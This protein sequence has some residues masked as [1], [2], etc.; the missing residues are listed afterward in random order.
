MLYGVYAELN[1][2]RN[3]RKTYANNLRR[4]YAEI[5]QINLRKTHKYLTFTQFDYAEITQKLRRNYANKFT[6]IYASIFVLHNS[7][8]QKLRRNYAKKITQSL[9]ILRNFYANKLRRITQINYA[10]HYAFYAI[11][12]QL[13][14]ANQITQLLKMALRRLRKYHFHYAVLRNGQLADGPG[15]FK[16]RGTLRR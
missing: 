5:T 15:Q 4:N 9:R 3:I 16:L 6:Q 8:T 7:I 13:N 10:I 1:K 14:Y 12:T 2:L 11:I